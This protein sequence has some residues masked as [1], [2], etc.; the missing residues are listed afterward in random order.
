MRTSVLPRRYGKGLVAGFGLAAVIAGSACS[1]LTTV[2]RAAEHN[3]STAAPAPKYVAPAD[4]GTVYATRTAKPHSVAN[5]PSLASYPWAADQS[6][7]PDS[8]GLTRRQ[9]VSYA[10]WYLNVHG[11]PFGY[12]TKGPNGKAVFGDATDWDAAA[13]QAGF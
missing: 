12:N 5:I 10:A 1:P 11:T 7:K 6:W 3:S 13:R 4:P 2:T 8:Y 9:C